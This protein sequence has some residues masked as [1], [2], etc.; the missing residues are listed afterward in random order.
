MVGLDSL[1]ATFTTADV[2]VAGVHPRELYGWRDS[3]EIVELSRG[4]FRRADA[5][6]PTYPD[7]LAV[8]YRAPLAVVCLVS[9]AFVC[10]T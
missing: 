7:L 2:R 8:A 6:T 3:G 1:P 4:V 10:G 5:S 9:A